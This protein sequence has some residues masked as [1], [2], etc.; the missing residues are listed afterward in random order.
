MTFKN[1][2]QTSGK[3]EDTGHVTGDAG[4]FILGVVNDT[5]ADTVSAN[6]EYTPIS[7]DRAGR[8]K[9]RPGSQQIAT[10][11][12]VAD[13]TA[14]LTIAAAGTGLFHY[15][16]GV[17]IV[18]VN[19]TA[20]AIAGSAV[21]LSYTTTNIP[22]SPAWTAGNALASG[23]EKVVERI[24]YL[25]GIKTTAAATATTFVAPAIG[26]GGVCRITVT[27]YIAF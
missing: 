14:T 22:G 10:T 23:A 1:R 11:I 4:V 16:T 25:G 7:T 20:A 5:G 15:I 18:N 21:T 27:Y 9:N 2:G 12:S 17:E 13:T 8:I 19:P 26:L 3:I 24:T 6:S